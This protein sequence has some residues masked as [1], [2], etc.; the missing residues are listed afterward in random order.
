MTPGNLHEKRTLTGKTALVTGSG[1]NIG[2]AMAL[3]FAEAGANVVVNGHSDQAAVET[4]AEEIRACGVQALALM[5]DVSRDD[6][7]ARMVEQAVQAFGS[8][9]IAVSNVGT[10]DVRPL[11]EITPEVWRAT[12]ETNLSSAFYLARAVLP[13]MRDRGWGRIIHMAGRTAFYP[14]EFRAH[15]SSSKAGLHAL[16]KVIAL[17]FG[18]HG[19]TANTIAPGIID[20]ARSNTTHPGYAEE[21]ARRS[22]ALPVRRLGRLEDIAAL[23][24]YLTGP[25]SGYITGQ[26]LH[27]NGGEFMS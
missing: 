3:A 16:A 6:Q 12:L 14:K 21:F 13:G 18:P 19:I 4:V 23:A 15:A 7:V 24:R 25:D 26:V 2:R 17:E 10:R 27:I 20:T 8:V 22:Q 5:A 9:D 11:L 1:R